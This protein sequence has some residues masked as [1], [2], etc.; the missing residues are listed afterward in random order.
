[1]PSSLSPVIVIVAIDIAPAV[2]QSI[3][4]DFFMGGETPVVFVVV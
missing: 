4:S 2:G 1:M 3:V